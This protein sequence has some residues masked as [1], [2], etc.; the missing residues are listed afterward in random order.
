MPLDLWGTADLMAA[1]QDD[2]AAPPD[3]FWL[4]YYTTPFL[5]ESEQIIFDQLP[6]LDRRLAPF[7]APHI[8]GR[9]MRAKGQAMASFSPAYLKPKHVVDPS[10]AVPRMP[11]EPILGNLSLEA[12]FDRI[13]AD[14]LRLQREMIERRWDWMAAMATIYGYVDVAGEDYTPVRVDFKRDPALTVTLAGTARWD[15]ADAN[16]LADFRA[17]RKT[18]FGL[19]KSPI[20]DIIFGLDAWAEF[21]PREDIKQLMNNTFRG[22]ESLVNITGFDDGSPVEFQGQISGPDG[23]GRLNLWTYSNEYEDPVDG[24]LK[25]VLDP[26]EVV[27]VGGALQGVRC[28]GA[29]RDKRAGLRATDMFAKMWEQEDPSVV[30]VMTQS[31]PLMVPRN[32]NNSFRMRVLS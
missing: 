3:G 16:P 8:Q 23:A 7:V 18:A 19:G 20:R 31:A 26:K 32:T 4:R 10:M 29:I 5:S 6:D 9:V 11:G 22:S 21:S 15:Q 12:R 2:R 24:V 17:V 25:P 1:Q 14:R 30:Y 13:V 28:F 27:G